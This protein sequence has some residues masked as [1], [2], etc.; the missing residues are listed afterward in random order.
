MYLATVVS[1]N[2]CGA[3]QLLPIF[4]KKKVHFWGTSASKTRSNKSWP[5]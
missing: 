3:T 2:R 4:K 1:A 5:K